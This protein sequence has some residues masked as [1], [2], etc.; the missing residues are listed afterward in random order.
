MVSE[1]VRVGFIII[2]PLGGARKRQGPVG[3][4]CTCNTLR[5]YINCLWFFFKY[6]ISISRPRHQYLL[7]DTAY[8][9][10]PSTARHRSCPEGQLQWRAADGAQAV[11]I[12]LRTPHIYKSNAC[13]SI[14]KQQT[15]LVGFHFAL[16]YIDARC[17]SVLLPV[18]LSVLRH[19]TAAIL[20]QQQH[21]IF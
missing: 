11:L 5:K 13:R 6:W 19:I 17:F 16:I 12:S 9:C 14:C 10:A 18:P 3:D 2:N 7:L 8:L 4:A 20:Q 21:D 15:Y 1:P